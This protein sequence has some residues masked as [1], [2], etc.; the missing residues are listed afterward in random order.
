VIA[1]VAVSGVP[2]MQMMRVDYLLDADGG[3][4]F[5]DATVVEI[6]ADAVDK[7][8][9]DTYLAAK[10]GRVLSRRNADGLA[11]AMRTIRNVLTS[12]GID[13]DAEDPAEEKAVKD[14]GDDE[15]ADTEAGEGSDRAAA[16]AAAAAE[17]T[18]PDPA[19]P[20]VELV[21]VDADLLREHMRNVSALA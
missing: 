16:S 14:G 2:G 3:V 9:E 17:V 12:A 18:D 13:V 8:L 19:V 11:A 20:P 7:A 15:L 10:E 21:P 6:V 5:G 1:A 4:T